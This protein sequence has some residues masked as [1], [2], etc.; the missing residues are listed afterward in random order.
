MCVLFTYLPSTLPRIP[1]N[2]SETASTDHAAKLTGV[3]DDALAELLPLVKRLALA[4]GC[5]DFNVLQ[6][7]CSGL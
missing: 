2:V 3:P 4:V 5:E 7:S 6:V 1:L